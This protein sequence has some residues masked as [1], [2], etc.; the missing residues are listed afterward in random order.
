MRLIVA[1]LSVAFLSTACADEKD[2]RV[3]FEKNFPDAKIDSVSKTPIK[4][5]YEVVINGS[6]IAYADEKGEHMLIGEMIDIKNRRNL[7]REKVEQLM[8]IDFNSLPVENAIKVVKGDGKR[9]LA[10]FSD[11]DCPFCRKLEL[12]LAKLNNVTIYTFPFPIPGL[13]PDA[14]RKSKLVW[15]AKDRAKA[16]DD[17]MLRNKLPENG[18]TDCANPIDANMAL[19][20]KLGIDGTPAMIFSNGKR[21]PGAVPAERIEQM[22]SAAGN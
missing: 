6:E 20:R 12:E 14:A 4:G 1:L 19:G 9:R 7:T 13:H 16:W 5:V 15:C 18:K 8:A 2:V 11:P 21:I 10:V 17:L 22:L 3:A